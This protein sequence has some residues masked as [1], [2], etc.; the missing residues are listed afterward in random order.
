MTVL[1]GIRSLN[2]SIQDCTHL[3][4]EA[5]VNKLDE[6]ESQ[7]SLKP[8]HKN[9]DPNERVR[10]GPPQIWKTTAGGPASPCYLNSAIGEDENKPVL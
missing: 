7:V 9:E 5:C 10:G 6:T 3:K 2:R 1:E 4:L 8:E